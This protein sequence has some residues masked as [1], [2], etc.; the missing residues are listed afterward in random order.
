VGERQVCPGG[1]DPCTY[2]PT[3]S[4]RHRPDLRRRQPACARA[5]LGELPLTRF[6]SSAEKLTDPRKATWQK[7]ANLLSGVRVTDVDTEKTRAVETRTALE[8]IMRTHPNLSTYSSFYVKPEDAAKLTPEEILMMRKYSE[9][10][11]R[12]KT[13][14]KEKRGTMSSGETLIA[15]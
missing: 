1:F 9:L 2:G 7:L 5:D 6:F 14:A 8:D 11:E 13:Y 12:A 15:D 3:D 10:Q 4:K